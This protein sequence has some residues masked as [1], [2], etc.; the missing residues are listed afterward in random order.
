MID[1]T[2]EAQYVIGKL[3][4]DLPELM[5]DWAVRSQKYRSEGNASY[6]IAYGGDPRETLDLF[7]S[8]VNSAPLLIYFHG[9]YWQRGNKSIYSFIA[10][11]FVE[12]G[13]DV[14]VVGY[15]LCPQVSLTSLVDSV[16]QSLMFLFN[17]ASE[18]KINRERF[19]LC[20][21][22]AGGHLVAMMMATR[23]HEID[24]ELP[25]DLVKFGAPISSLYQLEPLCHT[26]LNEAIGLD[27][28][29]AKAN[30]PQFLSPVNDAPILAAFGGAETSVFSTQADAY[31]QQWQNRSRTIEKHI[32]PDADHFDII[33]RLGNSES[34]IFKAVY[35]RLR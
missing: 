25:D 10:Q 1:E 18:L 35:Q 11:P 8:G 29:E 6:D 34:K 30:S 2:L 20:G 13:V 14:A 19:N 23:W 28:H 9:G 21:N 17:K 16:R 24:P 22:S 5:E 27:V 4:S 12:H 32:E 31:I 26:S 7:Y 33:D 15:P 3:R